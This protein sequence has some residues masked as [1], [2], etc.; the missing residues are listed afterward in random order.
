MNLKSTKYNFLFQKYKND[1]YNYSLYMIGNKF[2]AED[3]VQNVLLKI[4]ENLDKFNILSAKSWIIKTTHNLC[5]D[6]LRKRKRSFKNEIPIDD[7]FDETYNEKSKSSIDVEI[8]NKILSEQIKMKINLLPENLKSVF[9]LYEIQ[10]LK[11]KEISK[12]LDIPLN[13][14][15]VYLL[16]ARK[17]LQEDL[18]NYELQE[19]I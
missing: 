15:K 16:R 6:E 9:V 5:I 13:S 17:K 7:D 19:V 3:I 4:W 18:K 10:G 1:I 2:E 14:V 8:S 12:S 11:Y